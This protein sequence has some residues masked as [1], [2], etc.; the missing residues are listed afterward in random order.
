MCAVKPPANQPKPKPKP[1]KTARIMLSN[2]YFDWG[3]QWSFGENFRSIDHELVVESGEKGERRN[4]WGREPV[5][6]KTCFNCGAPNWTKDHKCLSKGKSCAKCNKTG[7][8][9]KWC[10]GKKNDN[11]RV[12]SAAADVFAVNKSSWKKSI[13]GVEKALPK[14]EQCL[15]KYKA[16]GVW[17]K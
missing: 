14:E 13:G 12:Q 15:R 2:A 7:H 17:R 8:F 16:I 3:P 4:R 6:S 1:K 9:A 10:R 11:L 5:I